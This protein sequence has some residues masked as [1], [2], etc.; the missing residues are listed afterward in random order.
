M[1]CDCNKTNYDCNG[2]AVS[3]DCVIWRGEA[4]PALGICPGDP[5]TFI[6]LQVIKKIMELLAEKDKLLED[7]DIS[8]CP[9]LSQ[10][11]VGKEPDLSTILQIIWTNQCTLAEAIRMM[12]QRINALQPVPYPF[13]TR[14]VSPAGNE[15]TA[16]A[17][18]QGVINKVC[19][20]QTQL[21]NLI[22]NVDTTIQVK[23]AEY[24]ANVLKGL[25]NR[26]I[27]KTGTGNE[28][29]FLFNAF[30]PPYTPLPYYGP[31]TNFDANSKG[32][33]GSPY[34]GWL[35]LSGHNGVP[36]ARGRTLVAAVKDIPG[37]ALDSE[38][39]PTRAE[40]A[41]TNYIPGQKFGASTIKLSV[42][43]LPSHG[44]SVNDPGHSHQ[45]PYPTPEKFS[46]S[47]F[48][49]AN[50]KNSTA[51]AT[52]VAKT[53]ISIGNTGSDQFHEN[54]QPSLVITGYIMRID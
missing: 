10:Q 38:V 11:L 3:S 22:P 28:L 8:T 41:G 19:D 6:E 21:T 39:D 23:I 14:C 18:L 36:D 2:V 54:R 33:V 15:S 35:L 53:G 4:I 44:H 12:D 48:D 30:V 40:N 43:Q 26:G 49:A 20:L 29:V 51:K 25:G 50:E 7:F 9:A 46:G 13:Q 47:K 37:P 17:I 5:L 16:N 52:S 27:V 45:A 42:A 1:A 31:I 24:L 32:L 34:E